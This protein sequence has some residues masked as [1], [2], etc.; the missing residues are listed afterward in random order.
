MSRD[1]LSMCS[2]N[3]RNRQRIVAVQ[4]KVQERSRVG[5]GSENM[6]MDARLSLSSRAG[7]QPL[8]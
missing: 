1:Y 5:E 6:T 2:W 8:A 4:E 7:S 3:Y